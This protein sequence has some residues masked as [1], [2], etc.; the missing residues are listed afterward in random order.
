MVKSY[1]RYEQETCFGVITS[2]SN[3]V[4]LPPSESQSKKSV[5]RAMTSGVEEILVW[6]I[7]TGEILQRL[8]DGL[9]PGASNAP[10]NHPPSAVSYLAYHEA[11]NIVASGYNDGTIKIWDLASASV[12]IKFQGHKS[13]IGKLKFDKSGTRLASG[14]ND[15]SI[16]LWDLVG[17]EG[18]FKLKG[19]KSEITDLTF[20]S[21]GPKEI[22][23]LD[24]YILSVS[25]DGL[26]KLWELSSKQCIETHI[27]HSNECWSLGLNQ[28]QNLLITSG[29][30]DQV[31]VWAIDLNAT[32]MNK[33]KEK[34]IFE[35]QSKARCNEIGFEKVVRANEINEIFYLQNSD[36]TVEIFRIR[37]WSELQK[38]IKSRTKRLKDKGMSE[39]EIFANI[40]DNEVNMM[41]TPFTTVRTLS[42]IKSCKWVK[43]GKTFNLLVSLL[44]NCIEFYALDIPENIKKIQEITVVKNNTIELQGHRNDVRAT[45]ISKDDELL[46]TASNGELKVW[47]LKTFNVLRSLQLL[48]GYALCCKFLP[49]GTL[50]VVGFRNG[51]LEL[52]DLTSS[53][54]VDKIELAHKGDESNDEGSAI[55]SLDLSP[56][57]K[58]L[59][60]GGNDK[61]VKFWDF[62]LEQDIIPG[63]SETVNKIKFNHKQT[64]ELS[65]EILSV[66]ISPDSRLLAISLL[67]NNVQVIYLDTMKLFLTLYGHKLP[68]LSMDIS[69]DS[70]LIITSSADK[71]IKIWGLDF[72]D[73]HKSIFGHQDSIMNVKFIGDSHNFFSSGKDG[74]I[75]YWDGDKFDCVQKLMAHQ[76]EVWSISVS[77]NGLF[78]VSTSHDHSI[79]L[80]TATTDQVFLEEER[81]KEIDEL[82]EDNLLN[83]LEDRPEEEATE[84]VDGEADGEVTRVQKQTME[85]LKAGEKLIEAVDIGHEDLIK[86]Q[87]FEQMMAQFNKKQLSVKPV[88]PETNTVLL[89]YGVTGTQYVFNT[90]NSIKSSQLEDA[91]LVLPFSYT[92]KLLQFIEIWAKDIRNL[93]DISLVCKI[94]NFLIKNNLKELINQRDSYLKT[95]LVNIKSSLR[96]QLT[97]NSDRINFNL[98]G[99]KFIKT[100]WELNHQ[101]EFIDQAEQ[102]K[103]NDS[104]AVKRTFVTMG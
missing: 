53:T 43:V 91:L 58:T 13:R 62:K 81:E 75:K 11:S 89:A 60:T 83:S 92:K 14:S 34:G 65:D 38:G 32:D 73:C 44:N 10:T 41:I 86:H 87:E 97:G 19:H 69:S 82:Y 24:D 45:D 54:L 76:L 2:Q 99:L 17:E 9:T 101:T 71:N 84:G 90:I 95:Q 37:T 1:S 7:K 50:V 67:N 12:I 21:Q 80:W 40:N 104:K 15:A 93:N 78:M 88:K 33:I 56:D 27:A 85:S 25:K 102:D 100:Q 72:G 30:K 70:K 46:V 22:D 55:W 42:K 3:I 63:T 35:K 31:K 18:L 8:S 94:L 5:G 39:E 68:V 96:Q 64:L 48:S 36:R 6:D 103:Y 57:G 4:W 28:E 77:H 49:G 52:Y 47:N 16:I 23:E 51:D 66:K 98:Q 29:N 26:I 74:V 59:V 61:C 79:R 20:I